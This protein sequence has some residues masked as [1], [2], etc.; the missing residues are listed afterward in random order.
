VVGRPI[1]NGPSDVC[2]IT[3]FKKR[4]KGQQRSNVIVRERPAWAKPFP[5]GEIYRAA[6]DGE[7]FGWNYGR[8]A[9]YGS[10]EGVLARLVQFN[11]GGSS[12]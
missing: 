9:V 7:P 10:G 3:V 8:H 5:M 2:S 4:G 1:S 11:D 6:F 12:S